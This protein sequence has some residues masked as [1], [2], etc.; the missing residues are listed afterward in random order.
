M[1]T[2]EIFLFTNDGIKINNI[3]G[4]I[5]MPLRSIQSRINKLK[6]EVLRKKARFE[7]LKKLCK[8]LLDK[9]PVPLFLCPEDYILRA[10]PNFDGEVFRFSHEISYNTTSP[11]RLTLNRFNLQ[12]E[13]VFYGATSIS[14]T[15]DN[16]QGHSTLTTILES[17]K[18]LLDKDNKTLYQYLT[19]GSW[20]PTGGFPLLTLTFYPKAA[21]K[22]KYVKNANEYYKKFFAGSYSKADQ[23][24]LE[25]FLGYFSECACKKNDSENNYLLTTAFFHAAQECYGKEIGILYSSSMTENQ[26]LNVVLTKEIVDNYLKVIKVGMYK[27]QRNPSQRM[28]FSIF[29][30][31][32]MAEVDSEGVFRLL[33]IT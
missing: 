20:A 2:H 7:I 23:N 3:D 25:I 5:A 26:G 30:C 18:Y 8:E 13:A 19:I 16:Q 1:P 4:K 32:D 28:E 15:M 21:E 22:S 33:H 6:K 24:K 29:P 12:G 31:S 11:E 14:N 27:C 17:F 9:V 10:R